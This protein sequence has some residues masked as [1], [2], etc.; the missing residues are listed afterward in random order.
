M[1]A[2]YDEAT[3]CINKF[4]DAPDEATVELNVVAGQKY[5]EFTPTESLEKYK[6]QLT[7]PPQIVLKTTQSLTATPSIIDANG[8]TK[9]TISGIADGSRVEFPTGETTYGTAY[10]ID[11]GKLYFCT[12]IV[13][14]HEIKIMHNLWL[15]TIVTITGQTP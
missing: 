14:T 4:I 6:V 8:V 7:D 13:G 12:D 10:N 1:Y 5:I 2:I 9:S 15:D 11:T 3:G